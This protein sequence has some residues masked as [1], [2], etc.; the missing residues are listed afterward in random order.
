ME[1]QKII[2]DLGYEHHDNLAAVLRL[3]SSSHTAEELCEEA[4]WL[5]NSKSREAIKSSGAAAAD[6]ISTLSKKMFGKEIDRPSLLTSEVAV[7]TFEQL[8]HGIAKRMGVDEAPDDL[9][10]TEKYVVHAYIAECLKKMTPR[11]RAKFFEENIET[12]DIWVDGGVDS[13]LKGPMRSMAAIG[14]AN[15]AG[16]QLYLASTTALGLATHAIG[17]TLP[18]AV[19]SG[20]TSTIAFL[21]G[22]PGWL[23]AGSWAFWAATGPEWKKL[24]PFIIYLI[25]ARAA[26]N[27]GLANRPKTI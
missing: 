23:A 8:V 24:L 13:G 18:F 6:A 15:A 16:F 11:Q 25:N 4:K 5:Y 21:I 19:Y 9:G 2:N 3:E 20:M 14:L 7:P 27:V 1:L 12:S 22:P 10:M 26:K 17:V